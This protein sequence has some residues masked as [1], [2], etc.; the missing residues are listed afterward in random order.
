MKRLRQRVMLSAAI[1]LA[2]IL[3]AAA[4]SFFRRDAP[5][6]MSAGSASISA[7]DEDP[8]T[9]FRTE[10]ETLRSRQI[11][12]LNDI[13]HGES[14]NAETV[15]LAQRQLMELMQTQQAELKLEGILKLRGFQDALV[16]VSAASVNVMLRNHPPTRQETAVILDLILR[17]TGVTAGNV[18]ILSINQ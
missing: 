13:I 2:L 10:R 14:T 3:A 7:A 8:V 18:K 16:T 12:E 6:A 9:R 4:S 1:L 17:E 5:R 11:G 15:S